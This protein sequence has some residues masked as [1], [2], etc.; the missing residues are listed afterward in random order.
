MSS[1]D[2]VKHPKRYSFHK[3][4][5]TD[6]IKE[7]NRLIDHIEKL[8]EVINDEYREAS[9]GLRTKYRIVPHVFISDGS[10]FGHDAPEGTELLSFVGEV[11]NM[12][13]FEDL[14]ETHGQC[15]SYDELLSSVSYYRVNE[16]ICHQ[17]GGRLM[18]DDHQT[19]S[20]QEWQSMKEGKIPRRLLHDILE[21][22][23]IAD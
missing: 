17:G 7:H 15:P 20:D 18:L 11:S 3:S 10:R 8:E 23:N 9:K 1:K 4:G 22:E 16:V 21:P 13:Q 6:A 5:T 19:C 12:Q 2:A 14:L